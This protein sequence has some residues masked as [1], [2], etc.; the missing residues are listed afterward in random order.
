M[1][2]GDIG[3]QTIGRESSFDKESASMKDDKHAVGSGMPDLVSIHLSGQRSPSG[4]STI[5]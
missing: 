3:K 4:S 1:A 5:S 2:T